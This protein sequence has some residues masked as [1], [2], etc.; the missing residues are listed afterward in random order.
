MN[1]PGAHENFSVENE[2]CRGKSVDASWESDKRNMLY[3]RGHGA[4]IDAG[5]F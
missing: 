4:L 3:Q 5:A 2:E 1:T